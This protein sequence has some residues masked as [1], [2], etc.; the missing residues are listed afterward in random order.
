MEC[1]S[2][3]R[4]M[5]C[6]C[7]S[8]LHVSQCWCNSSVHSLLQ[9]AGWKHYVSDVSVHSCVPVYLSTSADGGVYQTF[10]HAAVSLA[11]LR[12]KRGSIKILLRLFSSSC[13]LQHITRQ[14][15]DLEHC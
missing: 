6:C 8:L 5:S 2:L 10:T 12:S 1:V 13:C 4:C 15:F 11:T 3:R 9:P 7:C 14:Q